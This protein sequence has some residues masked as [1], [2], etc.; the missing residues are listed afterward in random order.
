MDF[1]SNSLV[2]TR[3]AT[4]YIGSILNLDVS[5]SGFYEYCSRSLSL[6][7]LR[8]VWLTGLITEVHGR[9]RGTYG[10]RRVHAELTL[11]MGVSVLRITIEKL[12][13]IAGV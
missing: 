4:V 3:I 7:A 8:R 12:M 2:R 6:T 1:N 9:S 13:R 5:R 11:G 10:S